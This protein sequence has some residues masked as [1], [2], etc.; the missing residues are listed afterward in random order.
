[1]WKQKAG[2]NVSIAHFVFMKTQTAKFTRVKLP[3]HALSQFFKY[4]SARSYVSEQTD[5]IP[6]DKYFLIYVKCFTFHHII[7]LSFADGRHF[8]SVICHLSED[9]FPKWVTFKKQVL[10]PFDNYPV[11]VFKRLGIVPDDTSVAQSEKISAR[12]RARA[13]LSQSQSISAYI[14]QIK[15]NVVKFM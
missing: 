9:G 2:N 12:A 1:M 5:P 6:S 15:H 14:Y 3:S 10:I 13:K 4:I 11:D 8:I 7:F